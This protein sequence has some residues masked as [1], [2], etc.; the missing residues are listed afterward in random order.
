MSKDLRKQLTEKVIGVLEDLGNDNKIFE[1][2]PS[3]VATTSASLVVEIPY[4]IIID[5]LIRRISSIALKKLEDENVSSDELN[6]TLTSDFRKIEE[7]WSSSW[8]NIYRRG[9]ISALFETKAE[10]L[11]KD[12]EKIVAKLKSNYGMQDWQFVCIDPY[13]MGELSFTGTKEYPAD[14]LTDES[15]YAVILP[16]IEYNKDIVSKVLG[17]YHYRLIRAAAI[18]YASKDGQVIPLAILTFVPEQ[19]RNVA[20]EIRKQKVLYH[21]SLRENRDDIMKN[22]IRKAGRDGESLDGIYYPPRVFFFS[23]NYKQN[24]VEYAREIY[25]GYRKPVDLFTV[26]IAKLPKDWTFH[27][28]SLIGPASVYTEHDIPAEAITNIEEL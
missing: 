24:A 7:Q 19:S 23:G 5:K 12:F 13:E 14:M 16:D 8:K 25:E 17:L 20:D 10:D 27:Y 9:S 15:L 18:P 26:D 21:L 4:C 3:S 6:H 22:G 2:T 28:D 11:P 1:S